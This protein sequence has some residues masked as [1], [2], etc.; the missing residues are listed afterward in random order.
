MAALAAELRAAEAGQGRARLRELSG[1][2]RAGWRRCVGGTGV[3]RLVSRR[4]RPMSWQSPTHLEIEQFAVI[5]RS[6]GGPHALACAAML[7]D[8][9]TRAGVLVR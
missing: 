3:R 6:G 7:P 4:G 9:V 5:G 8:R 2:G 1:A